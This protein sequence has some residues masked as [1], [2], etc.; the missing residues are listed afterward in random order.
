MVAAGVVPYL[1]A[2]TRH[3]IVLMVVTGLVP[4][5]LMS[6]NDKPAFHISFAPIVVG[7][8]ALLV[9]GCLLNA[10]LSQ[11]HVITVIVMGAALAT[12][13]MISINFTTNST[14]AGTGTVEWSGSPWAPLFFLLGVSLICAASG[15][16]I[17]ASRWLRENPTPLPV[18]KEVH[19]AVDIAVRVFTT[20]LCLYAALTLSEENGMSA[21]AVWF[22][23]ALLFAQVVLIN[24]RFWKPASSTPAVS[25]A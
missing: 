12:D 15:F 4:P 14:G 23:R 11:L 5:L 22:F 25:L 20:G 3:A 19:P 10:P 6:Q 16:A 1:A 2:F 24:W 7:V 18:G 9:D 13:G 21:Q 8:A 17:G